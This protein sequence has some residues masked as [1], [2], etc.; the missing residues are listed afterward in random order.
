[1]ARVRRHE[2]RVSTVGWSPFSPTGERALEATIDALA[3]A[4]LA[5]L[6][7]E[8][9]ILDGPR[10]AWLR[11]HPET[12]RLGELATCPW[13]ASVW[14]GAG[15]VLARRAAPGLWDPIARLLA[16]SQVAGI[17]AAATA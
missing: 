7:T 2:R 12:T 1:M 17:A 5:R 16:A 14:L 3:T 4:R 6:V 13:C 9:T 15:V 11:R 8:D 10:D